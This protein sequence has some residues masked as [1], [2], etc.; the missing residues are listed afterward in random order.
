MKLARFD[1]G[2]TGL[3]LGA[4]A[5]K[6]ILDIRASLAAFST[7]DEDA[8]TLL[9]PPFADGGVSWLPL[10]QGWERIGSALRV[11]ADWGADGS[12]GTLLALDDVRLRRIFGLGAN[13]TFHTAAA[14]E[15]IGADA[16]YVDRIR[17]LPPVGFFVIPGTVI[18][19]DD[20]FTPP[21]GAATIDYEGEV[22][23]VFA[24]GGREVSASDLRIWGVTAFNDLSIRDP[25]LTRGLADLD[26]GPLS[27]ALQKNWDGSNACGPWLVVDEDLVPG[28][29]RIL[30][31]V[32]GDVRQQG[33]TAEMVRTFGEG[34]EYLSTFI[35]LEP[36]DMLL[37]GTPAG[38]AIEAGVDAYFLQPGDVV[39]VEVEG[40]GV[41]RNRRAV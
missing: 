13:F 2:R 8:A 12:R 41:L 38:T 27:W 16:A 19:H 3:V 34:A 25:H 31:R 35:S 6:R 23:V 21:S 39:E 40:V 24:T 20:D 32:N 14:F 29:L 28:A 33:S 17:D 11:L 7:H 1:D 37:S 26:H 10:I 30:S 15:T 9:F 18:G 4:G 22:A 36:G 5:A